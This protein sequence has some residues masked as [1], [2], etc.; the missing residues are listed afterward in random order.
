MIVVN[1]TNN[2]TVPRPVDEEIKAEKDKITSIETI[3]Q[4]HYKER[5]SEM[6]FSSSKIE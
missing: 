1:N 3:C 4:K 6:R 5:N 2:D